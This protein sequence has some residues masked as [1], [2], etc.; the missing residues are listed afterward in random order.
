[1][2]PHHDVIQ[3]VSWSGS[4]RYLSTGADNGGFKIFEADT[5]ALVAKKIG[6]TLGVKGLVWL[7]GGDDQL[8]TASLDT[9]LKV[10]SLEKLIS[11]EDA[12]PEH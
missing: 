2:R 5:G 11:S 6:H 3:E 10:W 1:M 9:K 8:L 4:G 12:K 7:G